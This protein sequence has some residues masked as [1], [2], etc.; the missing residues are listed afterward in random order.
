MRIEF[1][2]RV[3]II[4]IISYE[5]YDMLTPEGFVFNLYL[6]SRRV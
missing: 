1:V 4:T 3:A 2:F 5:R 6:H